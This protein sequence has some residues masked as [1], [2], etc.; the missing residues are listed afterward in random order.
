[1]PFK[2]K[3]VKP[4]P[5]IVD[6]PYTPRMWARPFHASFRRWA[7]LI[8]HRRAGKTTCVINHHQRAAL[9]NDWE[10]RRLTTLLP[11][12]PEAVSGLMT[13]RRQYAHVMPSYKQAKGTAWL[14]LKDIARPVPGVKF[15][16]SELS[17]TYPNGNILTLVGADSPDSL[18]GLGLAGASLDEYSQIADNAFGEVISKALADQLGYGVF[19]GTIKGRDK[20]YVMHAAAKDAGD[21][22]ALWQD[23]DKSLATESGAT[24]DA[25]RQAMEDERA[26]VVQGVMTQDEFDQEWFLSADAAIKGA[27]YAKE[28]GQAKADGRICRVPYD[29]RLR[30]DT[31][32]DLGV[33]DSTAI[34]FSQRLGSGEI[35]I[36][37]YYEA[38][39]EGLPHYVKVLSDRKYAYGEHWAPHDIEVRE[40][41]SGKSRREIAHGLG[42]TFQVTPNIGLEDGIHAARLAMARCWF[43]EV[44]CQVGLER[45]RHYRRAWNTSLNEFKD[46]PV[47]DF[48]SHAADAFRGLAVRE[49]PIEKARK[50]AYAAMGGSLG[51]MS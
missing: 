24:I 29:A 11:H 2:A 20:L 30:V 35:R 40:L 10:R 43:D 22:F 17:V 6:I 45:L 14:M 36:I 46:T 21:W 1:V 48:S 33:G 31:D 4:E 15:N 12:K 16:E 23:I 39:G 9:D 41:G 32:W 26:L 38:S 42:L 49:R 19:C 44:K 28:L 50:P 13:K 25:L 18:R 27:I 3:A 47:H 51:W 37:D 5:R 8:L 7:C 34:W